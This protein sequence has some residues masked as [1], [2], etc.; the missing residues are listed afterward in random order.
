MVDT[1][2]LQI[3]VDSK[4]AVTGAKNLDGL[5]KS[6]ARSER[7]T[8]GL[9]S[10]F[11]KMIG[12]LTAVV[13]ATAGLTKLVSVAR[14]FDVL[15]AQLVTATGSADNA[16]VAFGAIQ[17]FAQTTPFDLAQATDGF[18]KLVNLGLT[19]SQEAM[20]SYGNTA[21]AMGK[22]LNQMIEAVADAATGEFERLKEF[23]IKAKSEGDNVSLTFQGVTTTIGK[24]A[25]EI[26]GYLMG[27]GQNQFAGAM[28][29]QM[30]TLN[31][32]ISNLGDNW[33]KLFLTITD[34]GVGDVMRDGVQLASE[35]ISDLN[36]FLASGALQQS[37]A[38]VAQS[39]EVFDDIGLGFQDIEGY[40]KTAMDNISRSSDMASEHMDMSFGHIPNNIRSM[41]ELMTVEIAAFIDKTGAYGTEIL[42]NMRFWEDETFDLEGRLAII[43]AA[44]RDSIVSIVDENAAANKRYDDENEKITT[45]LES[46]KSLKA[47]KASASAGSDLLGGFKVGGDTGEGDDAGS[48]AGDK[49]LE[50]LRQQLLTE[51]EAIQ[52]SY[53]R[54]LDIIVAN[55]KS[56]DSLQNELL[57][58]A[59]QDRAESLAAIDDASAS[60]SVKTAGDAISSVLALQQSGGKEGGKIAKTAAIA[61]ATMKTYESATSAYA[62]LAGI[63][64]VG[65]VLGA[66]AAGAA[67]AAGLA[68]VS[69]IKSAGSFAT[70]GIV[71]GTST[72]GDNLTANVNSG[73][74]ILNKSQ[75]TQLFS[76]A[77][78][79]GGGGGAG[80]GVSVQINNLLNVEDLA[81]A[82]AETREFEESVLNVINVNKGEAA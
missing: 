9:T 73:E 47:E 50:R 56:T 17:D 8:D 15:N 21:S 52:E 41:I 68:N 11:K 40:A 13:S 43:D 71:G 22:D 81:S 66:A 65:P 30:D 53:L 4:Q 82:I 54:R 20:L 51:E 67:V 7:A 37:I 3:K 78:G 79:G 28:S 33:D 63:P 59:A 61:Q 55:T 80:G 34:Q 45:V 35:A 64:Y 48:A 38:S 77:N 46:Y 74:M 26:E 27:L 23:G 60:N 70:G 72:S 6:G 2:T 16:A 44:R 1:A 5:T 29:A 76:Q 14:E 19:P 62:S 31:G 36:D 39:F 58:K 10:S 18:V 32:D 42:E 25:A 49:A 75:Q 57:V 24:N 69:Q 12:P